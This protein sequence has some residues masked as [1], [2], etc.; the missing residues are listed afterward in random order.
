MIT[1]TVGG[2]EYECSV[3]V[4]GDDF[5]V[6][7]DENQMILASFFHIADFDEFEIEGGDWTPYVRSSIVVRQVSISDGLISFE[8]YDDIETGTIIRF[9]APAASENVTQGISIDGQTYLIVDSMGTTVQGKKNI[10]AN[11]ALVSFMVDKGSRKAYLMGA[12]GIGNI[13]DDLEHHTHDLND[14]DGPLNVD[15]GGT[16]RTSF[17]LD[18]FLIG[19]GANSLKEMSKE[20]LLSLI[21]ES[22]F[23]KIQKG[24]YTGNGNNV[25]ITCDFVPKFVIVYQYTTSGSAYSSRAIGI[26]T[27]KVGV[28][29]SVDTNSYGG[30]SDVYYISG[31]MTTTITGNT[32]KWS[33][34][35]RLHLEMDGTDYQ[36]STTQSNSGAYYSQRGLYNRRNAYKYIAFG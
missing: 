30:S 16:G 27:D 17:T 20:E 32:I 35:G 5:I 12:G 36:F 11:G 28:S 7:Y 15:K 10:W 13:I 8:D 2:Q 23:V 25:S 29:F 22:G 31:I 9:L 34:D 3:A 18:S 4:R 26:F 33:Y 24:S 14:L 21:N 6:L 1:V 19:N